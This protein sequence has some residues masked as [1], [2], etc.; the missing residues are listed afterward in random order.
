MTTTPDKLKFFIPCRRISPTD[1]CNCHSCHQE[2]ASGLKKKC[3]RCKLSHSLLSLS[4]LSFF[5]SMRCFSFDFFVA[6][7]TLAQIKLN[8]LFRRKLYI[9]DTRTILPNQNGGNEVVYYNQ[10]FVLFL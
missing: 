7:L 5:S 4:C 10:C 8:H 2:D 1:N 3:R 9:G 6:A